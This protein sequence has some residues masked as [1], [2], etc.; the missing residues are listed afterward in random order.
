MTLPSMINHQDHLLTLHTENQTVV[1]DV[2]PGVHIF[3]LMLDPENGVWVIRAQFEPG[4]TLPKHFHTGIVHL[5]TMS[6]CWHYIEYPEDKQVA[7]S[8]LFEPGG[9][10]HTFHTPET[11]EGITDTFMVVTG[12]NV[13]FDADGN[14]VNVMDAGWIEEITVAAAKAQGIK[15]N[16]IKPGQS[17]NFSDKS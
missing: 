7:G 17:Y 16:Y 6:G 15:I 12:S 2:L 5:Y 10:I 13:N 11:N 4:V 14:F 8:Y 1:K 3:P 9:S